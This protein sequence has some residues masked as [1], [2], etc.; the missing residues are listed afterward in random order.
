MS[1]KVYAGSAVPDGFFDSLSSLKSPDMSRI[2][3]SPAY[4]VTSYDFSINEKICSSGLKIS[5]ISSRD[6]TDLL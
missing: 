1:D 6:A 5:E 2:Y 4:K 3:S